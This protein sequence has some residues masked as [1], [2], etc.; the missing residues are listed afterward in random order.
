MVRCIGFHCV[1]YHLWEIGNRVKL[2][3]AEAQY[4]SACIEG[5]EQRRVW[6]VQD[7]NRGAGESDGG[8]DV[9]WQQ[10]GAALPGPRL[11]TSFRQQLQG[12][13]LSPFV[14]SIDCQSKRKDRFK[15]FSDHNGSLLRQQAQ[16]FS[17]T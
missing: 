8:R 11:Q 15:L 4:A 5:D 16:T 2:A 3:C 9:L 1:G 14:C 13:P 6:R 12:G 7:D 10:E 17:T